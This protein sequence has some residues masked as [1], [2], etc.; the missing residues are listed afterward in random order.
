MFE[1]DKAVLQTHDWINDNIVYA[2]QQLLKKSCVGVEGLQ[3]THCVKV[4][5][6]HSKYIQILHVRG[7]HWIAISN[8]DFNHDKAKGVSGRVLIYDSLLS[9]RI[10][11][12][13][14]QQICTLV[15][16]LSKSIRLDVMN[17]MRQP[18]AYDCGLFSIANITELAFGLNPGKCVW[19]TVKMRQHLISCLENQKMERFPVLKERRIPF[20]GA[21][22]FSVEEDIFCICRMPYNKTVDMIQCGACSMWFHNNCVAIENVKD[23]CDKKWLCDKCKPLFGEIYTGQK[24]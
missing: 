18:N 9:K 12:E 11:L 7:C 4:V 14:K 22:I 16:P 23:Y 10:N 2:A 21:V 8:I 1:S 17:I 6:L 13:T 19:D 3:S 20:G 15:R 24:F 5:Q